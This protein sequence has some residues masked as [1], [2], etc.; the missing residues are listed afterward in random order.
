MTNS[1]I[2]GKP[3]PEVMDDS[4]YAKG[5]GLFS[6][7]ENVEFP[8]DPVK[9]C[10]ALMELGTETLLAN[11]FNIL[12]FV[13]F[14][15]VGEVGEKDILKYSWMLSE[16][17]RVLMYDP[18]KRRLIDELYTCSPEKDGAIMQ[19]KTNKRLGKPRK[20]VSLH[21]IVSKE[22]ALKEEP[23]KLFKAVE[24][25]SR[26]LRL[27]PD[28]NYC[29]SAVFFDIPDRK[30]EEDSLE[31]MLTQALNKDDQKPVIESACR[32][33]PQGYTYLHQSPKHFA[34]LHS[35]PG[36]LKS[37][38]LSLIGSGNAVVSVLEDVE[39]VV[40]KRKKSE[41]TISIK[42]VAEGF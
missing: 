41:P 18:A 10:Q 30:L 35:Y 11:H 12:N 7:Y 8:S 14:P 20:S 15:A 17:H 9:R 5:T 27:A 22:M 4:K 25:A 16:S 23:D 28:E 2:N 42:I 21:E 26:K 40:Y 29:V 24:A 31:V 3:A 36:T 38:H 39:D 33:D 19:E 34:G 13:P 32:Y 1:T 6:V 37:A